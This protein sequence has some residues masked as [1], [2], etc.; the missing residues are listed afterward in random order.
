M[1]TLFDV[2]A[3]FQKA[4]LYIWQKAKWRNKLMKKAAK[5]FAIVMTA[6][7][8]FGMAG[9]GS[10][11]K[12]DIKELQKNKG[13]MLVIRSFPQGCMTEEEYENG[14]AV[15]SVTYDGCAN[16]P[17]PINNSLVKMP[18]D[19]Y[20]KIYEFCVESVEKNKFEGYKEDVCDGTT[21]S[22]T[23]YDTD[24]VSHEIYS[25]YCYDNDEL[26]DVMNMISKYSLD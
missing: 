9:C 1:I 11:N 2:A 19:E 6:V 3:T 25:G 21:Y 17:N 7:L 16:N 4:G 10:K 22:F 18:D 5:I 13:D 12:T 26:Q 8:A 20:L 15:M 23:Y 24:G 14:K